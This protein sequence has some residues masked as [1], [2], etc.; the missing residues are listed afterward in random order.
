MNDRRG[1]SAQPRRRPGEPRDSDLALADRGPVRAF[2]RD[3]VDARRR[4]VGAFLPVLGAV[5]ICALNPPSDW[6]RY[7]LIAGLVLLGV[8]AIDAVLMGITI[9]RAAREL[10][11]D[12]PVPLG[13]TMWYAFLR[14]HRTRSRR[15]PPPRTAPGG[16][17]P[18]ARW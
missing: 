5:V 8:I 1:G 16:R 9:T 10:L 17:D 14:A 7:G 4:L 6:Q 12:E 18:Q 2:I 13:A 11:P 15:Y 3:E